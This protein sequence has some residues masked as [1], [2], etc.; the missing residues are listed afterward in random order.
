MALAAM[1]QK[2]KGLGEKCLTFAKHVPVIHL[3]SEEGTPDLSDDSDAPTLAH[4]IAAYLATR[5]EKQRKH[6]RKQLKK[7]LEHPFGKKPLAEVDRYDAYEFLEEQGEDLSNS[8]VKVLKAALS[9]VFNWACTKRDLGISE[10]PFLQVP[11]KGLGRDGI[12]KRPLYP[13]EM[14]SLFK[15]DMPENV[16]L[17]FTILATT[18]MRSGNVLNLKPEH[19]RTS[20]DG[21]QH[22]DIRFMDTKTKG[23]KAMVPLLEAVPDLSGKLPLKVTQDALNAYIDKVNDAPEVSLHSLRHSFKDRARD[24]GIAKEI[25]DYITGHKQGDIAGSY[26]QG[27]SLK[28]RYENMM[29]VQHPYLP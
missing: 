9:G 26:G 5:T 23:T 21:I 6:D 15:L 10:N 29:K 27:P 12:Q 7:W 28:V 22:L 1:E 16:R 3:H 14:D 4:V 8:S 18:G 20:E 25:Q 11:T 19:Y 2:Q 13:E 24:P 17:A